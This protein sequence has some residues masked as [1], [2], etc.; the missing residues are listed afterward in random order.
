VNAVNDCGSSANRTLS[1]AVT[2]REAQVIDAMKTS[3]ML[4]PNPTQG[5]TTLEFVS[6]ADARY[7][8]QVLDVTGRVIISEDISAV[9]GVNMH[10]LDFSTI[11]KGV[12][13]L[14]LESSSGSQ[15]LKL[16]VE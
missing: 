6:I 11:A 1:V 4:Y 9:E 5:K 2:C 7:S 16:T 13:M 10:E 14:R 3:A 8:L 15:L 12:Y